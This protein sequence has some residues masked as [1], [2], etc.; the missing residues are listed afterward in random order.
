MAQALANDL[1]KA[2]ILVSQMEPMAGF[3]LAKSQP[4]GP[5]DV[6]AADAFTLTSRWQISGDLVVEWVTCDSPALSSETRFFELERRDGYMLPNL[7]VVPSGAF[8]TDFDFVN[9]IEH[10]GEQIVGFY[11][12]KE[13]KGKCQCLA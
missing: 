3:P 4:G 10:K 13:H 8:L 2:H 11:G 5:G 9:H 12:D 6:T 7:G 1:P